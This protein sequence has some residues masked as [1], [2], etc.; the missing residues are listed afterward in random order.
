MTTET[1]RTGADN[2]TTPVRRGRGRGVWIAVVIVVVLGGAGGILGYHLARPLWSSTGMILIRPYIAPLLRPSE[3]TGNM[4]DY[5]SFVLAQV[6][7]LRQQPVIDNA[8]RTP[9]WRAL[10]RPGT[11]DDVWQDFLASLH[12]S[13]GSDEMVRV[14]FTDPDPAACTAAVKGVLTAYKAFYLEKE[15]R[16]QQDKINTLDAM[17][18]ACTSERDAK[19]EAIRFIAREFAT[20]DLRPVV[21]AKQAILTQLEF[22]L[23]Q[24]DAKLDGL[25]AMPSTLPSI[26]PAVEGQAGTGEPRVARKLPKDMTVSDIVLLDPMMRL[27]WNEWQD[28]EEELSTLLQGKGPNHPQMKEL[29]DRQEARR[30]AI[31]RYAEQW[32]QGVANAGKG[33]I[34]VGIDPA[35]IARRQLERARKQTQDRIQLLQRVVK[36]MGLTMLEIDQLR[37]EER[38]K[39]K[40]LAEVVDRIDTL[41]SESKA[42]GRV[43]ILPFGDRPVLTDQR[44]RFAGMGAGAGLFL[45]VCL[46]AILRRASNRGHTAL[47]TVPPH[48]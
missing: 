41:R 40:N 33:D 26:Q 7:L 2:G 42:A 15:E 18:I 4:P 37:A 29:H 17:R 20:D 43:E 25:G 23:S 5:Q 9:E 30:L 21:Q 44:P 24:I 32:R 31:E 16:Q 8:L 14:T 13:T 36:N 34:E 27:L 11:S 28:G 35:T 1:E 38:E 12:I 47:T 19:R 48:D 45:G 10:N 46:A 22:E 6:A 3:L 39:D